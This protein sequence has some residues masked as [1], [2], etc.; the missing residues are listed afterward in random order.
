MNFLPKASGTRP[1]TACDISSQ[2]VVAARSDETDAPLAAVARVELKA[3]AVEP[4]LK[5]GNIA[6]RV[7]VIAAVRRTL[8]S[9]GMKPNGREANVSL[10][11]PD[12]AV[13]VLLLEFDSLP[14]K[15]SEALPL[16]RFRLKRM[17]PFDADEAM[18]SFQL[19][20][21]SKSMV[22]VLAVAVPRD[23]LVEYESVI[24][25]AGFEPGAVVPQTL[26]ALA[27]V[28]SSPAL[29]V[30][31]NRLGVTAAIVQGSVL[32]LHRSVD[33]HVQPTGIAANEPAAMMEAPGSERLPLVSA[34]ETQAEWAAQEPLPEYGSNPYA[35][36]AAG[37][38][39][40]Q[41]FDG[42]T[43]LTA[44]T[45]VVADGRVYEAGRAYEAEL[46]DDYAENAVVIVPTSL[47]SLTEDDYAIKVVAAA[48]HAEPEDANVLRAELGEEIARAVSVA[49][50]YFED[51]L[52][53]AP[54][55]ILST[56]PL[57]AAELNRILRTHGVADA[58]N[59]EAREL[60]SADAVADSA[61]K[62]PLG[63]L[64]GVTGALR[65]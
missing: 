29:V 28:E 36:R 15:L 21:S 13:R 12:A 22:K 17:L 30:N 44:P 20:S 56:G 47:Q 24:R 40:V 64:A 1:R 51:T 26:A 31:A 38:T 32:L 43:A 14:A 63:W 2:G 45:I 33:L 54:E 5:P 61:T 65:G 9:V 11:L 60:V 52:S 57:G 3:G 23:V 35:D 49:V 4:G 41:G 18:V 46:A 62:I 48:L 27:A 42:I 39:A 7:A 25:E 55:T 8:E 37:E 10:V 16:V 59:V 6:D 50:A 34:D 19:M 58:E 53:V